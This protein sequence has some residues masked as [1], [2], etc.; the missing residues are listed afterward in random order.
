M[1]VEMK[2]VTEVNLVSVLSRQLG[3]TPV[4]L[5]KLEIDS[6]V[7]DTIPG[8]LALS[9]GI[10]PFSQSE[11][12]LDLAMSDPTNLGVLDELRMRVQREVRP[13]LAGPKMIERAIAR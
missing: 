3:M 10:V 4:D 8:E 9:Y 1:L 12:A 6:A 7:L 5:D 11:T 13:F 2:L